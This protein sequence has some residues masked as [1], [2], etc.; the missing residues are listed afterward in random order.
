[1]KNILVINLKIIRYILISNML[2]CEKEK[3]EL[4]KS[5]EKKKK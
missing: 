2:K 4:Q 1:M 5:F 3:K